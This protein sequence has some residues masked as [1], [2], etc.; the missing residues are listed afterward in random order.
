MIEK[1]AENL[2]LSVPNNRKVVLSCL[3]ALAIMGSIT[4]ASPALYR[5]FCQVTGYGGTTQRAIA[6]STTVLDRIVTVRFDANVAPQ[7]AW[8][9]EPVT[10]TMD[11]KVGE[12]AL[13]FFRATNTSDKP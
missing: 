1:T 8:T 6:P 5:L 9:F 12:N 7:L 4:A 11:V 3:A 2:K 10:P 13:A